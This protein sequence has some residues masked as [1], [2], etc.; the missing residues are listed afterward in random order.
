MG[1]IAARFFT[2]VQSAALY[3]EL[4][5]RAVARL[6][7]GHG[8]TWLDVGCGPGL[9]A[10]CAQR[11]GYEAM[12]VDSDP[13]MIRQAQRI[14]QC[15]RVPARFK[16]VGL[17]DISPAGFDVVCAASFLVVMKDRR[18]ALENLKSLAQPT[19]AIM[20]IE[21]TDAFTLSSTWS[22]LRGSGFGGRNWVMLLWAFARRN[23]WHVEESDMA[24]AGWTIDRCEL[25][26]GIAS[27]L[28]RPANSVIS[29]SA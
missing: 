24:I 23:A 2:Y 12:G 21:T 26:P 10:R 9:V 5:Q 8:L 20:I 14:A 15:M 28:L 3:Q 17:D 25:I 11:H 6:P 4:H 22:H 29:L 27:W 7:Q 16:V 13:A 19:G 18:G 1:I